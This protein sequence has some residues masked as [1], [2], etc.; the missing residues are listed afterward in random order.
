M[1][2]A[3][4]TLVEERRIAAY[5]VSVETCDEALAAI[6]RPGR[7]KRADHPQLLPARPLARVLPV[8]RAAGV[9]I[10]ARV[11]LASGL[12]SGRYDETTTFAAD[13][14]RTYNRH[15]EAFDVG[16]TFSGVDFA[17]GLAAVRRLAPLLPEGATMAQFALRW[18][19][20]QPGRERGDPGGAQPRPGPRQ[21]RR[22]RAGDAAGGD[23]GGGAAGVRR[24]HRPAGGRPLV[25]GGPVRRRRDT[26]PAGPLRA[27]WVDVGA[28]VGVVMAALTA[29]CGAAAPPSAQAPTGTVSGACPAAGVVLTAGPPDG[30]SGLR[31][32]PLVLVNCG[33]RALRVEGYPQLRILDAARSPVTVRVHRGSSVSSAVVDPEARP[34]V[35][36]PGQGAAASLVWRNTLLAGE[37]SVTGEFVLVTPPGG[38]AGQDVPVHLDLGGTGVV[39]VLAWAPYQAE[40]AQG[41]ERPAPTPRGR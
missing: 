23:P 3:L 16:E 7:G 37:T 32:V 9:G 34:L 26:G 41:V 5:G 12:L 21:R 20:D 39:D 13:D 19:V 40:V 14:H 30:A 2:D 35:L 11:P 6:T 38:G 24:A 33:T 27:G 8:A 31:A 15:G 1:F 18:I 28:G 17:V 25:R 29:G 22:R 4:D 10:I 36:Q